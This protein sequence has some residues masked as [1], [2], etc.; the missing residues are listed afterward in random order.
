MQASEATSEPVATERG[1][2]SGLDLWSC[3][4]AAI[5]GTLCGALAV[6]FRLAL[7]WGE[8]GYVQLIAA[9]NGMVDGGWVALLIVFA[10]LSG[11]AGWLT[12]RFA[13]EA[14]GS[15]IP[16]VEGVLAT[17][18]I[19]RWRIL[20]PVKFLAGLFAL[21]GGMSLGREG[22][23]VQMG[24][25]ISE[26]LAE[27]FGLAPGLRRALIAAG[28]GAGLTAAF[29]APLAG[30]VF[31]L[32]ELG[33]GASAL[34]YSTGLIATVTSNLVMQIGLGPGAI[35]SVGDAPLL[36]PTAL[37]LFLGL[38]AASGILGVLFNHGI[39]RSLDAFAFWRAGPRWYHTVAA[40]AFVGVVAW[41]FPDALGSGDRVAEHLLRSEFSV[42]DPLNYLLLLLGIKFLLT[43]VC[44]GS[45]AP[46]GLFAP[47]L[48]LGATLGAI[49]GQ[50]A[51]PFFDIAVTP[52]LAMAGMVGMFTGSVRV[53]ITG[54][55]LILEMTNGQHHVLEFTITALVA[56]LVSTALG[57]RP[58]YETLLARD[59]SR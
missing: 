16:H 47:L 49:A 22:P 30:F 5:G 3:I 35:F 26:G 53:P 4:Y 46:G 29:N 36:P 50:Y 7:A 12:F 17:G 11:V 9:A 58:I 13:P 44:Y 15:G 45:G 33:L 51:E 42:A 20:L 8:D 40:G 38:G 57:D 18:R 6:L 52:A 54:V 34:T 23:T 43:L 10:A 1:G 14:S 56:Y 31:V 21:G 39:V 28:A 32:E 48:A 2:R 59:L 37:W 24:A 41:W 25:A 55:V 19:M 27:R